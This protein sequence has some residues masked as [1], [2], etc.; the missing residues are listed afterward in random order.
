MNP[1]CIISDSHLG[2][3]SNNNLIANYHL[4]AI[5]RRIIE[6]TITKEVLE[7]YIDEYVKLAILP[8]YNPQILQKLVENNQMNRALGAVGILTATDTFLHMENGKEKLYI[9]EEE[10]GLESS[11]YSNKAAQYRQMLISDISRMQSVLK[12]ER[13]SFHNECVHGLN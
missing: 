5:F 11:V 7:N 1:A 9:D 8:T 3:G 13:Y 10:V 4:A 2:R 6:R 12:L